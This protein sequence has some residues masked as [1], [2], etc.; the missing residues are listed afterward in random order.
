MEEELSTD[1]VTKLPSECT[2][3]PGHREPSSFHW[4]SLVRL[5]HLVGLRCPQLRYHFLC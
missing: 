3:R 1:L 4:W 2:E 5:W